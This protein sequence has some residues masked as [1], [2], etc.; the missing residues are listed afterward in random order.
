MVERHIREV[1]GRH[2]LV[3]PQLERALGFAQRQM[4]ATREQLE[5]GEPNTPAAAAL[6]G[7][8]V[9]ALNA[10][11]LALARSRGQVAGARSGT[12]FA[13]AVE[14][15]ARLAESQ[16][17]L[18]GQ[19]QGLLPLMGLGG[20]AVLEQLRALAARQ[21]ALAEQLERLQAAGA[22]PA[23]GPLAEE[24][25]ELARQ[26]EAGR[27]D[28]QT[29]E[30]QSRL[31]RRL[32]DAAALVLVPLRSARAQVIGEAVELERTGRQAG[33]AVVYIAVLRGEATNLAALLGLERVLPPLGRLPELLPLVR[34]ALAADSA[35]RAFRALEVRTLAT[36]NEPD[37]TAGA[38]R[39]WIA[40]APGDEGPYREWALALADARR[41]DEARAV[42]VAGQRALEIGR[43]H[44]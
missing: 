38:A 3:S 32:L 17:G 12:G 16:R 23:A 5:Q 43:A 22:S 13:E 8:A 42:L 39:R 18:N 6:A 41:F 21:R 37:S 34:R 30:R 4:A 27:L 26:L 7:E 9:D 28:R 14:Q 25:R 36:L 40:L 2:A 1:A 29:I 10:T 11:A 15:L 24:A 19:A 44:V 31:Y 33:A 20:Q 35:N